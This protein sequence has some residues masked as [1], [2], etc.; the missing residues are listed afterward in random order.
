M[1]D[2]GYPWPGDNY[3]LKQACDGDGY[4]DKVKNSLKKN[5]IDNYQIPTSFKYTD[6]F[7]SIS[8]NIDLNDKQCIYNDF[9]KRIDIYYEFPPLWSGGFRGQNSNLLQTIKQHPLLSKTKALQFLRSFYRKRRIG[10]D[11]E[12]D[13]YT[14]FTYV[15]I[16][17]RKLVSGKVNCL[18]MLSKEYSIKGW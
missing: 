1:Y 13:K 9:M 10:Y 2:D 7:N 15:K 6:N 5:P 3:A 14:F 12:V 16:K 8:I 17:P 18:K 4:L 11:A